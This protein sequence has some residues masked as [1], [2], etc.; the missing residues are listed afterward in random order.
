MVQSENDLP[1]QTMFV[2][3]APKWHFDEG[4]LTGIDKLL[5]EGQ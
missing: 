5:I 4:I 1:S 3:Q 2:L